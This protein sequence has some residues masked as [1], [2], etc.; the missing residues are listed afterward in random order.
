MSSL[1]PGLTPKGDPLPDLSPRY[2]SAEKW[3]A[4]LSLFL[5]GTH[6]VGTAPGQA[7]PFVDLVPGDE[8]A[9][10]WLLAALLGAFVA[11]LVFEFKSSSKEARSSTPSRVRYLVALALASAS[12]W[13]SHDTVFSGTSFEGVAPWWYFV[14]VFGGLSLSVCAFQVVWGSLMIR[15]E[16]EADTLALPQVPNAARAQIWVYGLLFV[17][18]SVAIVTALIIWAP[19]PLGVIGWL[20]VG[21]PLVASVTSDYYRVF[22][23]K[24]E[25][26]RRV[27]RLERV[28]ELRGIYDMHDYLYK[29]IGEDGHARQ[30]QDLFR[31]I[32]IDATTPFEEVQSSM[33]EAFPPLALS[34]MKIP[35]GLRFGVAGSDEEGGYRLSFS[36]PGPTPDV[37][38]VEVYFDDGSEKPGDDPPHGDELKPSGTVTLSLRDVERHVMEQLGTVDPDIV[39]D[40]RFPAALGD[41]V[42]AALLEQFGRMHESSPSRTLYAAAFTGDLTAVR[43]M[44]DGRTDVNDHIHYG[45]TALQAAAAQ[46]HRAVVE[47]LLDAGADPDAANVKGNTPL[48]FAAQYGDVDTCRLLLDHGADINR[49]S[50]QRHT[51]LI[52]ASIGG[53]EE[54]VAL[55]LERDADVGIRTLLEKRRAVDYAQ[56][57]GHGRVAKLLRVRERKR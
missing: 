1:N 30:A 54:V 42:F 47:V 36:M 20:L 6:L 38:D 50:L 41:G 10:P 26:G 11:V 23:P 13:V 31:R 43:A 7:I 24:G 8:R 33:R 17:L 53:H 9:F 52:A 5:L 3:A 14:L 12:F 27:S 57:N 21:A 45:W 49:G 18:G 25:D 51:P 15:S 48:I 19:E 46:G 56:S 44:L 22:R 40:P 16:E 2:Y 28:R 34:G 4:V 32:G 35:A 37:M 55:L 39:A 29:S